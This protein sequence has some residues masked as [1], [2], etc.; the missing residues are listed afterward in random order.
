MLR[1]TPFIPDNFNTFIQWI[2]SEE[3]LVQ[4]A[5][6]YFT[7]PL[8]TQQLTAYLNDETSLAFNIVENTTNNPIGHAE[9]ITT[10]NGLCKIDKLIIG[11][12]QNRGKGYGTLVI[13]LLLQYCFT[14]L[15]ATQ[16]E[17]NVYDWNIAGMRCYEKAGFTYTG[18]LLSTNF[19]AETWVAKN[20]LITKNKWLQVNEARV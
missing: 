1:L 7:Y 2:T 5:G 18:K 3:L 16:V 12:T 19:N 17:L 10:H 9:I 20:M 11:D 13:N 14:Q 15:N 6:R 8:T 4:I